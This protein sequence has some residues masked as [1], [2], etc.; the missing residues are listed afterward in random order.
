MSLDDSKVWNMTI[1]NHGFTKYFEHYT[2]TTI[3]AGSTKLINHVIGTELSD[4]IIRNADQLNSLKKSNV[5]E[6]TKSLVNQGGGSGGGPEL[7]EGQEYVTSDNGKVGLEELDTDATEFDSITFVNATYENNTFIHNGES[8]ETNGIPFFGYFTHFKAQLGS[9]L[10]LN[11]SFESIGQAIAVILTNTNTSIVIN[12]AGA[13]EHIATSEND[14]DKPIKATL[15]VN[16]NNIIVNSINSIDTTALDSNF[17]IE[18]ISF[19]MNGLAAPSIE[20]L[21]EDYSE[22][23]NTYSY[24][25]LLKE[26]VGQSVAPL[27]E[28]KLPNQYSPVSSLILK[29]PRYPS[30]NFLP[31]VEGVAG[32]A[33]G[34]GN[35]LGAYAVALGM[36][37]VEAG[38]PTAKDYSVAIGAGSRA[39]QN[40]TLAIGYE[41]SATN[42][43]ALAIGSYSQ[44]GVMNSIAIGASAESW[45]D[46]TVVLGA[47]ANTVANRCTLLGGET[48]SD[49]DNCS[50]IGY[51]A[52]T[53][54]ENQVQLGNAETTP[55]AYAGLQIRSDARDKTNIIG[56]SLGLDFLLAH[57]VVQYKYNFRDNYVNDL[58]PYPETVSK[59]TQPIENSFK[60]SIGTLIFTDTI[61]YNL[62]ILNYEADLIAYNAYVAACESIIEQRKAFFENPHNN[63]GKEGTRHHC[64]F[65]AQEVAAICEEMGVD[66][67]GLQHHKYTDDNAYDVFSL[68]YEAYVPVIVKALQEINVRQNAFEE[69]LALLEN[70]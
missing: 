28:G 58:F 64:G 1:K 70:N 38:R 44:A 21:T 66:F 59:P 2:K 6:V 45:G 63:T 69:R 56:C 54:A 14:V 57:N 43:Q 3:D 67:S 27:V 15:A 46:L 37:S 20:V 26:E 49:F 23:Y 35:T 33:L 51:F 52:D 47:Y 39:T 32:L 16:E 41:S 4:Q 55:Y 40:F 9:T 5:I 61:A 65:I 30:D 62:A 34:D 8:F 12:G 18:I 19:D 60:K 48:K 17:Y 25:V 42:E 7:P 29:T 11:F 10:E 22:T 53:S 68:G 13:F 36:A 24:Q 31:K 50:V